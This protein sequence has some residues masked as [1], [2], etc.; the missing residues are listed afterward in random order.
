M[1]AQL[2]PES[3]ED[4]IAVISLYRPGPMESIPTYIRNR[5]NPGLVTYKHPLLTSRIGLRSGCL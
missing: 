2:G 4:L 3:I 1:I 5:H